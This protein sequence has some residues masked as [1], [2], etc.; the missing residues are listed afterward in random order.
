L[1]PNCASELE[2]PR[3]H[4]HFRGEEFA[5]LKRVLELHHV[6]VA[7][8]PRAT[9]PDGLL[10]LAGSVKCGMT[11]SDTVRRAAMPAATATNTHRS[12]QGSAHASL[13][14]RTAR[15]IAGICARSDREPLTSTRPGLTDQVITPSSASSAARVRQRLFI[16]ALAMLYIPQAWYP[17]AEAPEETNTTRPSPPCPSADLRRRWGRAGWR[18]YSVERRLICTEGIS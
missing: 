16:P 10:H 15:V 5:I 4:S 8:D 6:L 2:T 14:A 9:S 3:S 17:V 13:V 11:D 1:T 7:H 12:L 18:R